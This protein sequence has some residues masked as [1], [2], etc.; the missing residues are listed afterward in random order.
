MFYPTLSAEGN[1]YN[2]LLDHDLREGREE[3]SMRKVEREGICVYNAEF[4]P[5]VRLIEVVSNE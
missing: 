3:V 5:D 2:K 4:L 1:N